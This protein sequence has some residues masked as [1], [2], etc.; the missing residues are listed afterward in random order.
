M[1]CPP[2]PFTRIQLVIAEMN[3]AAYAVMKSFNYHTKN[4]ITKKMF[5]KASRLTV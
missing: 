4:A 3:A 5:K 1:P 2:S